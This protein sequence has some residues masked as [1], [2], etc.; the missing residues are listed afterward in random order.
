LNPDAY[1]CRDFDL[2][3]IFAFTEVG[4]NQSRE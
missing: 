1:F 4:Q 3:T 2:G